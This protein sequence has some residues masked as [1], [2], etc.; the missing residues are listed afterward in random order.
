MKASRIS[1]NKTRIAAAA[2]A[3]ALGLALLCGPVIAQAAPP[4]RTRGTIDSITP[5]QIVV[6]SRSGAS[7]TYAISGDTRVAGEKTVPISAIQEGSYI[8]SAAVPAG[9][10]KLRALEV[11]V[12]PPAMKGTGEGSYAWDLT[13]KSSMTNGTVGH[14]VV[15]NGNTMTVDYGGGKKV[16]IVPSDVPIVTIDPGTMSDLKPGLKVIVFPSKTDAK[17]AGTIVYGEN[18]ISPP[19]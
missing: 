15:S 5:T 2:P 19:Q 17:T 3:V 9:G 1:M 14:L 18:G 16:I 11:T 12:F 4:H 13:P 10:G 8:G 6:T 7:V